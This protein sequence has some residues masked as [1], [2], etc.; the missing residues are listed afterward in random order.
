MIKTKRM[1]DAAVALL[2][3]WRVRDERTGNQEERH[4][5]GDKGRQAG[6]GMVG[7]QGFE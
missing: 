6:C 3:E 7:E 5:L 4:I 1:L 2:C